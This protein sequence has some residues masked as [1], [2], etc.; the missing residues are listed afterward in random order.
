MAAGG[1]QITAISPSGGYITEDTTLQIEGVGLLNLQRG[2]FKPKYSIRPIVATSDTTATMLMPCRNMG[3]G[4]HRLTFV[5]IGANTEYTET[6]SVAVSNEQPG[7]RFVCFTEPRHT[8]VRP[9]VGPS[10][11]GSPVV[12]TN[13][14]IASQCVQPDDQVW[15]CNPPPLDILERMDPFGSSGFVRPYPRTSTFARCRWLCA[16][17]FGCVANPDLPDEVDVYG[18]VGNVTATSITCLMPPEVRVL[19][20]TAAGLAAAACCACCCSPIL[21]LSSSSRSSSH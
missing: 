11:R 8:A 7:V 2:I 13:T 3:A 1:F 6:G 4:V 5:A 21:L 15:R 20:P 18:P 17:T 16:R 19:C 14:L 10:F 9:V 12:L